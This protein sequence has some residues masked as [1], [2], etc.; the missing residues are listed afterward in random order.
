MGQEDLTRDRLRAFE[1][2][3]NSTPTA[4]VAAAAAAAAADADASAV[5]DRVVDWMKKLLENLKKREENSKGGKGNL[6]RNQEG[7]ERVRQIDTKKKINQLAD[8]QTERP[9]VNSP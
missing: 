5:D 7:A 3:S 8:R 9:I 6:K 1:R 2:D 4:D